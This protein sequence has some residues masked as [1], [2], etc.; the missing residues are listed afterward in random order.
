MFCAKLRLFDF[1]RKIYKINE[2]YD[3]LMCFF[4]CLFV[5]VFESKRKDNLQKKRVNFQKKVK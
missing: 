5:F 3:V 2:N 1:T 4:V